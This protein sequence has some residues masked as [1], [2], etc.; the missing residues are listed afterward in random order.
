MYTS[1]ICSIHYNI[2]YIYWILNC[3]FMY[4]LVSNEFHSCVTVFFSFTW[5]YV[6]T[7]SNCSVDKIPELGPCGL[8]MFFLFSEP[9]PVFSQKHGRRWGTSHQNPRLPCPLPLQ[10]ISVTAFDDEQG[11]YCC[12]SFSGR[13]GSI[14]SKA[15]VGVSLTLSRSVARYEQLLNLFHFPVRARI[16][17]DEGLT[18]SASYHNFPRAKM[19]EK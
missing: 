15:S 9:I 14:S 2:L 17:L 16:H 19:I 1:T 18:F 4:N 7:R 5:S 6:K 11:E 10:S 3:I 12:F 13:K 8:R